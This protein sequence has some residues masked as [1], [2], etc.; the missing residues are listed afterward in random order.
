MASVQAF[1]GVGKANAGCMET[2]LIYGVHGFIRGLQVRGS[3][4]CVRSYTP[5]PGARRVRK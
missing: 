3:R 5:F 1:P 2:P 4:T